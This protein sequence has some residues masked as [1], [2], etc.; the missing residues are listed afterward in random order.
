M[1]KKKEIQIS[2]A[3]ARVNACMT[4]GSVA[5]AMRVSK[6]TVVNWEKGISEPKTSQALELSEL[7]K[8]PLDYIFLPIKSN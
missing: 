8:M 2:L 4:Q 7:Y 1:S 6:Q 5:K 3:A